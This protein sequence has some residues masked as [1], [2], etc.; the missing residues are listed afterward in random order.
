MAAEKIFIKDEYKFRSILGSL[1][2]GYVFKSPSNGEI[3]VSKATKGTRIGSFVVRLKDSFSIDLFEKAVKR[4]RKKNIIKEY[5]ASPFELSTMVSDKQAQILLAY[6]QPRP[7]NSAEN[8][9]YTYAIVT[10]SKARK[11]DVD[12][13]GKT[14][15]M[16][17][18]IAEL[19]SLDPEKLFTSKLTSC[20]EDKSIIALKPRDY[21]PKEEDEDEDDFDPEEE[22]ARQKLQTLKELKE[23]AD[24]QKEKDN[25]KANMKIANETVTEEVVAQELVDAATES[26]DD[27]DNDEIDEDVTVE[28]ETPSTTD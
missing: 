17:E 1:T 12:L 9:D 19:L 20:Q 7:M 4:L 3:S 16:T 21:S 10:V 25:A 13:L 11:G 22:I 6:I 23:K 2:Q 5:A 26:D 28:T 24:A 14:V 8:L 15:E 27:D 18:E